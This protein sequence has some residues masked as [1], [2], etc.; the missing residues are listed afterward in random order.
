MLLSYSNTCYLYSFRFFTDELTHRYSI[1]RGPHAVIFQSD[2]LFKPLAMFLDYMA[3]G[4][5]E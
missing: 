4:N 2:T 3:F 1:Y 5:T